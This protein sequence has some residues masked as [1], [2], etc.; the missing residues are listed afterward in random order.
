MTFY[1]IDM[2]ELLLSGQE[3]IIEDLEINLSK[4]ERIKESFKRDIWQEKIEESEILRKMTYL[5]VFVNEEAN[6]S[7]TEVIRLSG[8]SRYKVNQI[9]SNLEKEGYV[10]LVSQRP[11]EYSVSNQFLESILLF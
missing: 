9:M 7:I 6:F 3:G 8:K 2:L 10:Q 4:I 11:K 1:L 5:N